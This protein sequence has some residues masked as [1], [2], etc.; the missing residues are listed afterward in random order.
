MILKIPLS[1]NLICW[2]FKEKCFPQCAWPQFLKGPRFEY[3]WTRL[4]AHGRLT[5]TTG[6]LKAAR[7]VAF[8]LFHRRHFSSM[9]RARRSYTSAYAHDA[10]KF[11]CASLLHY[12]VAYNR[13]M[14]HQLR[15]P[16]TCAT[17]CNH[18]NASK[19][20]LLRS[21]RFS[22]VFEACRERAPFI[23]PV[24]VIQVV[25]MIL[26]TF[27]FLSRDVILEY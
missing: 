21:F 7:S 5:R 27:Y 22:L 20:M 4:E 12:V 18:G 17:V 24:K 13:R 2:S 14:H 15:C 23:G 3:V 10:T 16:S 6:Q 26:F 9:H 19:P 11:S 1:R 8:Q 25:S